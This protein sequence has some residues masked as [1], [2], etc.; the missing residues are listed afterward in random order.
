MRRPAKHPFATRV[1]WLDRVAFFPRSR[2]IRSAVSRTILFILAVHLTAGMLTGTL[3]FRMPNEG[4][5]VI[6]GLAVILSVSESRR[7]REVL[8]LENLGISRHAIVAVSAVTAVAIE[9]ALSAIATAVG[10]P[11]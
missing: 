5:V 9:L 4:V 1:T 10:S 11:G 8:W 2:V 7:Q 3:L 6:A